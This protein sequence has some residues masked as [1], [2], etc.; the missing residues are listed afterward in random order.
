MRISMRYVISDGI[1]SIFFSSLLLFLFITRVET[2]LKF[3]MDDYN[4]MNINH[5]ELFLSV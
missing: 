2:R 4:E 5:W 3:A 1:N